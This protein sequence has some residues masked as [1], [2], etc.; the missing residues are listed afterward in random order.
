M[1]GVVLDTDEG[2]MTR[3]RPARGEEIR[4]KIAREKRG[5]AMVEARQRLRALDE[6]VPRGGPVHV[7]DVCPQH[8]LRARPE[9]E[10]NVL[11]GAHG[12]HGGRPG[13]SLKRGQRQGRVAARDA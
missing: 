7:A 1:S 6:R 10:G 12:E 5:P 13:S 8:G 2:E 3:L 4:M 9:G 11:V